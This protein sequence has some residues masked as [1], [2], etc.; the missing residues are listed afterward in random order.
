MADQQGII[1]LD[2]DGTVAGRDSAIPDIVELFLSDLSRQGWTIAFVTGRTFLYAWTT[3][4]KVTFPFIVASE[5]GATITRMP[6]RT[7][8]RKSYFEVAR[9]KELEASAASIGTDILLH[10]GIEE[11]GRC[12]YRPSRLSRE[13]LDYLKIREAASE[14]P[15]LPVDDFPRRELS[16]FAYAKCFGTREELIRFE[17]ALSDHG[18]WGVSINRDPLRPSY[19]IA[20]VTHPD[21]GKGGVISQLR[22]LFGGPVIAAGDDLNDLPMLE[23]ADYSIAMSGAPDSLLAVATI[24]A[25]SAEECGIIEGV[26]RAFQLM[27]EAR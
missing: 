24:I 17:S 12:Y 4:K 21:G 7:I 18:R 16:H 27:G 22:Q 1:A 26:G 13:L 2:I 10:T 5:N 6:D 25:P 9:I 19:S 15:W 8:L 20:L 14:E 11:G 23:A 3:L